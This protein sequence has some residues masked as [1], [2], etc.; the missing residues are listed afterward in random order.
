[1]HRTPRRKRSQSSTFCIASLPVHKKS[2]SMPFQVTR[3][4]HQ[5]QLLILQNGSTVEPTES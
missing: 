1:M 2:H 4:H 3:Q 5:R